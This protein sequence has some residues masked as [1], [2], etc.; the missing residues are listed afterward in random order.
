MSEQKDVRR[1]Q[2]DVKADPDLRDMLTFGHGAHPHDV[3]E[4]LA[5]E[6]SREESEALAQDATYEVSDK[7]S[8][9]QRAN[10]K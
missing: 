3:V 2:S 6:P 9:R 5:S 4:F 10:E 8:L 1:K 7:G